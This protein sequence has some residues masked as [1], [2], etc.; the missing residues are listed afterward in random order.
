MSQA[1]VTSSSGRRRTH[2]AVSSLLS[3]GEPMIWLMAGGLALAIAMVTW[4]LGL[5][6]IQGMTTFWPLAITE[7]ELIDGRT[8]LGQEVRHER[9]EVHEA[10]FAALPEAQREAARLAADEGSGSVRRVLLRTGNF[11]LTRTRFTWVF[12]FERLEENRPKDA[13]LL[14]RL[15]WGRFYGLPVRF[16]RGGEVLA[17]GS[18]STRALLD[19]RLPEVLAVREQIREIEREQIADLTRQQERGRLLLR[20]EQQT[21]EGDASALET[22]QDVHDAELAE[23][24]QAVS[25][26]RAEVAAL[27]NQVSEDYLVLRTATG[28]EHR[29]ALLQIVRPVA[30]NDLSIG[31]MFSLYFARWWEF[32]SDDPREANSEGGVFPAI[33]GTVLMTLIMS[34]LVVPF[35][36]MAAL[37]LREY[38][39]GGLVT[40]S[41]RIAI[42]N[43][44]GVPSIVFGVFGLGFFCYIVGVEIDQLFYADRLPNPTFG[45]GALIWASFTLALLTLPV[46]IVATEEAIAAVPNSMREGSYACGASKWQTIQRIVLP[47]AMPGILTGTILA[48]ARGAGEVAPLMIVGAVKLAPELPISFSAEEQFGLNRSFM[49]LGFHIYDLG[50]QSPDSEAARPMVYTTTLLLIAIVASLNVAA[51]AMRSRLKK[52]FKNAAF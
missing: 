31:E 47:R 26:L 2:H 30:T 37:Y 44:A 1:G 49:H 20:S 52:R 39:K 28:V 6:L 17:E 33:F 23:I 11:E 38:A 43:L 13:M 42:N 34:V 10:F 8:I 32:L 9:L 35:G 45:K 16:E 7:L 15:E 40:S 22:A 4:L 50:F 25:A 41:V 46:V 24:E 36:V 18:E 21:S 3:R 19:R 12:D 48:M 27:R 29:T 51:I 14:E 5:V